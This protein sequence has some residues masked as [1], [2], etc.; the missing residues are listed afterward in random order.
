MLMNVQQLL[1]EKVVTAAGE[2]IGHV[3]DFY[4]DDQ[5]WAIRYVVVDTGSWLPGRQVLLSPLSFGGLHQLGDHFRINLSRQQI[6]QGPAFLTQKPLTRKDQEAYHRY[7][8]WPCYWQG[9]PSCEVSVGPTVEPIGKTLPKQQALFTANHGEAADSHM[10]STRLVTGFRVQG[11]DGISGHVADFGIDTEHWVIRSL[12]V[13]TGH[14]L[15][16]KN[17]QLATSKV[18]QI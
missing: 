9:D 5:T 6:E 2:I 14:R 10:R 13:K 17:V 18:L 3:K 7:F 16:G 11:N 4:F 8:G 15:S 1:G 12:V